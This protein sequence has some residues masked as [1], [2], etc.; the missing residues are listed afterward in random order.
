MVQVGFVIISTRLES[1]DA[2]AAP[3]RGQRLVRRFVL[4]EG[5]GRRSRSNGVGR[6]PGSGRRRAGFRPLESAG[7]PRTSALRRPCRTR[8][9]HGL[10]AGHGTRPD[11]GPAGLGLQ[12]WAPPRAPSSRPERIGA[13]S[14]SSILTPRCPAVLVKYWSNTGQILVKSRPRP[15]WPPSSILTQRCWRSGTPQSAPPRRRRHTPPR[16]SQGA[17]VGGAGGAVRGARG[18]GGGSRR[19]PRT[20]CPA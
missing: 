8:A 19:L 9:G 13:F 20:L 6:R 14:P 18:R 2:E 11:T 5:P 10:K 3:G 12:V 1:R 16:P 4:A 17:G 15:A 7:F